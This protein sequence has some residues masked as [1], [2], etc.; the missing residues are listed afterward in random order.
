MF[1]LFWHFTEEAVAKE[2]NR[3]KNRYKNNLLLLSQNCL[4]LYVFLSLNNYFV[5]NACWRRRWRSTTF[6]TNT[7]VQLWA[8]NAV[9][10]IKTRVFKGIDHPG[11]CR[12][13]VFLW[14]GR[15]TLKTGIWCKWCWK[16][17]SV[18]L[19]PRLPHEADHFVWVPGVNASSQ[20]PLCRIS[21][22]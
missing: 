15:K 13:V 19:I 4:F 21:T 20:T 3:R 11:R 8:G 10:S 12:R 7:V 16:A 14:W 9:V 2:N 5:W 22:F 6:Q 1:T 17:D 18:G